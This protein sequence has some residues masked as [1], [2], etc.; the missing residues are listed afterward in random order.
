MQK[1]RLLGEITQ[2]L[3]RTEEENIEQLYKIL[4]CD[5][6]EKYRKK[7]SGASAPFYTRGSTYRI[8]ENDPARKYR[9]RNSKT[10]DEIKEI[11]ETLKMRR[12][13]KQ[14]ELRR[15]AEERYENARSYIKRVREQE[16]QR[17]SASERPSPPSNMCLQYDNRT[18]IPGSKAETNGRARG[19]AEG[20]L[21]FVEKSVA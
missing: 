6:A 1:A 2:L 12:L 17:K 8:P 11:I 9:Y 18:H 4:E 7:M 19:R 21:G 5:C 13:A 20:D 10:S 15:R 14:E 16:L 3:K